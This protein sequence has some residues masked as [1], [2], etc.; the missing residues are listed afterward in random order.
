[1]SLVDF[2]TQKVPVIFM[3]KEIEN[4]KIIN[5][6]LFTNIDSAKQFVLRTIGDFKA[7]FQ[8]SCYGLQVETSEKEYTIKSYQRIYGLYNMEYVLKKFQISEEILKF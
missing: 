3:V 1:M 7:N 8:S 6:N 4:Q 5:I 2:I